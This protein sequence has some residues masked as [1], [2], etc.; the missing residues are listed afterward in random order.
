MFFILCGNWKTLFFKKVYRY[1]KNVLTAMLLLSLKSVFE[2]SS[3]FIRY[4]P[5]NFTMLI[6][7]FQNKAD[8]ASSKLTLIL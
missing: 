1:I 6:P 5:S 3:Y 7:N 8:Y 4:H 2:G